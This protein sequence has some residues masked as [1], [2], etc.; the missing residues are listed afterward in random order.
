MDKARLVLLLVAIFAS[1]AQAARADQPQLFFNIQQGKL[2]DA[3][4]IHPAPLHV[5]IVDT[6]PIV[7]DHRHPQEQTTYVIPLG[8][9]PGTVQNTVVLSPGNAQVSGLNGPY[10]V[11]NGSTPPPTGFTSNIPPGGLIHRPGL[12]A[13]QSSTV[14]SGRMTPSLLPPK[15]PVAAAPSR[16][17]AP[18][19][20]AQH[21]ATY[22]QTAPVSASSGS[23]VHSNGSVIGTLVNSK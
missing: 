6:G 17:V 10:A 7:T 9:P 5:Q 4:R 22:W 3:S 11:I 15:Q 23:A 14:L 16:T 21:I 2:P 20:Q 8:P 12:P 18:S 19:R 13:G 1:G